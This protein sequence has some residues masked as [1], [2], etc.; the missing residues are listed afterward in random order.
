MKGLASSSIV[1]MIALSSCTGN[2]TRTEGVPPEATVE[3]S[4]EEVQE[5]FTPQWMDLPGVVGTGIGL[6]EDQP[7]IKV[8]VAGPTQQ[9]EERIPSEV[10]GYRVV[11]EQTGRFQA[12]DTSSN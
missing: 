12:R 9:L 1:L 5:A 2:G 11:L 3:R 6:C 8:F 7:C 4:I 10:E